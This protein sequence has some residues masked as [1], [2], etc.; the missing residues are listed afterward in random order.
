[1]A[2]NGIGILGGTF[3]PVH[4]GHLRLAEEVREAL[5]LERVLFMPVNL[6][7]HK[8][9]EG[10]PDSSLRLKMLELATADNA[11]FEVSDIELNRP[12]KSFTID[13]IEELKR[14]GHDRVTILTGADQFNG[15][16]TW[17]RFEELLELADFAVVARP[18]FATKKI[19]EV[20]PVELARKFCYDKRL[21]A[22]VHSCGCKVSY[23]RASFLDISSSDIRGRVGGK[24]SIKYLVPPAVADF[25]YENGLYVD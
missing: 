22:Y 8:S 13:T 14:R 10:L 24:M 7:P 9:G 25:I 21:D 4:I 23:A 2:N 3:N 17:C 12:G 5:E 18:G 11:H 19:A 6:P 15:I 16:A 20:L 1:M